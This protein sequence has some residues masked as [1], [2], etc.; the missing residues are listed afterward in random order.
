METLDMSISSTM[1]ITGNN[2]PKAL[3]ADQN[4]YMPSTHSRNTLMTPPQLYYIYIL[5]KKEASAT[6]IYVNRD[7]VMG[8]RTVK[9]IYGSIICDPCPINELFAVRIRIGWTRTFVYDGEFC[10]SFWGSESTHFPLLYLHRATASTSKSIL[11]FQ[12]AC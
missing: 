5:G 8:G 12:C 9:I 6:Y 3:S 2:T 1:A 4:S 11:G 10:L 7:H